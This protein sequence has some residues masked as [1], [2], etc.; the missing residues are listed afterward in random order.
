MGGGG[1]GTMAA[2]PGTQPLAK[3]DFRAASRSYLQIDTCRYTKAHSPQP[4]GERK[5]RPRRTL[6]LASGSGWGSQSQLQATARHIW[7]GGR[8]SWGIPRLD[9]LGTAGG[10]RAPSALPE[11]GPPRRRRER[12]VYARENFLPLPRS[13]PPSRDVAAPGGPRRLG[14][15]R[16]SG[17]GWRRRRALTRS[18]ASAVRLAEDPPR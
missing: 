4:Q 14:G 10:G 5:S 9:G 12:S 15:E 1:V 8:P 2:W 6:A 13:L 17:G 18:L 3:H 7:G 11:R 16:R